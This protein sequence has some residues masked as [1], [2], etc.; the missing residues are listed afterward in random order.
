MV[1]N[2]KTNKG[3]TLIELLVVVAIIG[4]LATAGIPQYRRM[5]AKSRQAEAKVA[6]GEVAT[7]QASFFSEYGAYGNNLRA[8][9]VASDI[10]DSQNIVNAQM[11]G[12]KLYKYGFM[13]A[14][15]AP[16]GGAVVP[17]VGTQAGDAVQR[18]NPAYQGAGF[19]N[20]NDVVGN[21][22]VSSTVF[23]R[24]T[25]NGNCGAAVSVVPPAPN[26]G[27]YTVAASGVVRSGQNLDNPGN[28]AFSD[29]W[30]VNQNRLIANVQHGYE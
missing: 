8:M 3:F 7:A 4:I 1:R 16:A 17:A 27:V 15:C 20:V 23:G 11:V 25:R 14:A 10:T 22:A 30:T 29:V 12:S 2:V 9:G 28:A 19:Q 24:M 21:Q 18:N 6:L 26:Y 5:V 13:D